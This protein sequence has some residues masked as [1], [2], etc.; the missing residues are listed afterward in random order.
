MSFDDTRDFALA[1]G[2]LL[3][4]EHPDLV[5]TNM[6]KEHRP[7]RVFVDWSQNSFTKT[8]IAVYSLRARPRPTVSTP[9]RWDEVDEAVA[10]GA[11]DRLRFDAS[12][13]LARVEVGGR[14]LRAPAL[15]QAAAAGVRGRLTSEASV[16]SG[17][18]AEA[19]GPK[20]R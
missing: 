18:G 16:G 8:T 3:E 6:G 20:R 17:G 5:T 13:V 10:D 12:A 7:N 15:D 4:R 19:G 2:Q 14:H 1:L 9:L 11:A